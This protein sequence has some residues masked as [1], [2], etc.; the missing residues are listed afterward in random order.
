[1]VGLKPK[2]HVAANLNRELA[3][4]PRKQHQR[5]LGTRR[6]SGMSDVGLLKPEEGSL[7][8]LHAPR[9][10]FLCTILKVCERGA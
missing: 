5:L 7:H 9:L 8:E 10:D 3:P 1:M 4:F 2:L 6:H